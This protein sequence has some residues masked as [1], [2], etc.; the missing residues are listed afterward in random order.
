[1]AWTTIKKKKE[2]E[3]EPVAAQNDAYRD[4]LPRTGL[5]AGAELVNGISKF[6]VAYGRVL[7]PLLFLVLAGLAIWYVLAKRSD[8]SELELRN[9]IDRAALVEKFDEL[10]GKMEPMVGEAEEDG[11]LEAYARYRFAM[12][13][14]ELIEKPYKKDQLEKLV[15][16][17]GD[18]ESKFGEDE[19]YTAWNQRVKSLKERIKADI[20]FFASAE[21]S[22]GLPWDHHSK[23]DKPAAKE[24]QG[25]NPIVVLRTSVGDVRIEL[26]ETDA[27]NAVKHLVSLIDEG[28]YD[29]ADIGAESFANAFNPTGP[30]RGATVLSLGKEGRPVGVELK[31]P[32][33]AKEGE[34]VDTATVE[35]PYAI[36]YEGSTTK[37]FMAG[38]VALVRSGDDPMRCRGHLMV[39]LEPSDALGQNFLP[40]GQ[41]LPDSM[42]TARRLSGATVYYTWVEQKRTGTKY[43]PKVYYDGW[44]VASDKREKKPDPLR[45]RNAPLEINDKLNPLV[46]IEME[47]G[48]IVIELYQDVCPNTV[49]NF[50]S[51]IEERFFDKG[52]EFYRVEG[53]GA[54][55]AEIYRN[56]GARIIQGGRDQSHQHDYVIKNEA[57]D[58]DKYM[59]T[60][61]RGTIAMARTSDLDSAS[62]EFFVNLRD[63]PDWDRKA[64]PYCVFGR[65]IYGLELAGT[66]A[67]DDKITGAKV[68]RKRSGEYLPDVKYKD[69]DKWGTKKKV[70]P[71]TD[72]ELKK[73][74]E[75]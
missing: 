53:S 22:A 56:Q 46:V 25:A 11:R 16:I 64:S 2:G 6:L 15:S 72:E 9:R 66:V 55:V 7:T 75:K 19:Q 26:Y 47:K 18:Y 38:S 44:P 37:A 10:P 52:C 32:T 42:E 59:L 21:K 39:V 8:S 73:D 4:V 49:K 28:Y 41:V 14:N 71:P 69:G 48:D 70:T 60:N 40:L 29:R 63:Y 24:V 20:E 30:F 58:N 31:K 54:D 13:A 33:T 23:A 12:R 5:S 74:S 61:R 36:D 34:D 51:L 65:V 45:F 17:L 67:K 68:I 50:V 1:M 43:V 62:T 35:N 27:P 57:V 3:A